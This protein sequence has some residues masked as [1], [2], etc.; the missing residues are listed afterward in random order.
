[1][2]PGMP[3]APAPPVDMDDEPPNKKNRTEDNLIPENVFLQCHKVS[4]S[5]ELSSR[6]NSLI[7][8]FKFQSPITIQVQVPHVNDKPEWRLNGQT[9]SINIG[10]SDPISVLKS[11]VQEETDMPPAKQKILY[12]GMFF[13]DN[14]SI[15]YYNLLSGAT[16]H[17]Q[18]KE[19]GGRKK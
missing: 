6:S 8:I 18:I 5:V 7:S 12:D 17:L 16:V 3:L 9:L 11:K 13:K 10:L 19:R 15:A 4:Q 14:N 2:N 1:M